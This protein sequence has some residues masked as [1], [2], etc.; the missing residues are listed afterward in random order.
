MGKVIKVMMMMMMMLM[1]M[2]MVTMAT[3]ECF[4]VFFKTCPGTGQLFL[5]FFDFIECILL[6][7]PGYLVSTVLHVFLFNKLILWY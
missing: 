3:S 7:V 1:I 4:S 5:D 6:I 2:M